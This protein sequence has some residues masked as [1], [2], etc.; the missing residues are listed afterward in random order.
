MQAQDTTS[1]TDTD[2]ILAVAQTNL[3]QLVA[4]RLAHQT[5]RASKSIKTRANPQDA[6]TGPPVQTDRQ[7]LHAQMAEVVRRAGSGLERD[8][9]WRSRTAPG[10]KGPVEMLTLTGNSANAEV[11]AKERVR[12]VCNSY[13]PGEGLT[14]LQTH[15]PG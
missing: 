15:R 10:T 12:M 5:K 2:S 13:P 1:E 14:V 6:K 8:A 4:V 7:K 3:S 9:R 11:V